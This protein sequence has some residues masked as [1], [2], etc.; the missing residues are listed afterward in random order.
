[1]KMA[2]SAC[3]A[4]VV[5]HLMCDSG[6]H[7]AFVAGSRQLPTQDW[8]AG[9]RPRAEITSVDA[10]VVGSSS[11]RVIGCARVGCFPAAAAR[12]A[13]RVWPADTV[14]HDPL[15]REEPTPCAAAQTR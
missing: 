11:L 4:T 1:M 2:G 14:E 5:R 13:G 15:L 3:C 12:F 9:E 8:S 6:R 10:R 7:S